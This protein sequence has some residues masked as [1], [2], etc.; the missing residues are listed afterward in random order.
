MRRW[1]GWHRGAA[2]FVIGR[3]LLPKPSTDFPFAARQSASP[4]P[5]SATAANLARFTSDML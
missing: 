5:G 4:L 2:A 1:R 3:A